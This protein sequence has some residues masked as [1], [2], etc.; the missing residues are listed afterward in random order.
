MRVL[1]TL[2][3]LAAASVAQAS[4]F[5]TGRI[6]DSADGLAVAA[7]LLVEALPLS[8][9]SVTQ[10]LGSIRADGYLFDLQ[11]LGGARAGVAARVQDSVPDPLGPFG[12]SGYFASMT[13]GRPA[14]RTMSCRR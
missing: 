2:S 9:C 5:A 13:G 1:L 4:P 14:A 6:T 3:F 7:G 8:P 12:E 11:F 10:P